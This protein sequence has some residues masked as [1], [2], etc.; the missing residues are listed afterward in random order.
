MSSR[1]L[2][3]GCGFIILGLVEMRDPSPAETSAHS[4]LGAWSVCQP[5]GE[6]TTVTGVGKLRAGPGTDY[7]MTGQVGPR[8]TIRLIARTEAGDWY[9]VDTGS[10]IAAFLIDNAPAD[11]PAVKNASNPLGI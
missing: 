1:L 7:A 4:N 8:Q 5:C 10:W 6:R 11:L 9:Q 2:L 3:A